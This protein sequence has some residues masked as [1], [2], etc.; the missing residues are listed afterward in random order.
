MVE[1]IHKRKRCPLGPIT[2]NLRH[3]FRFFTHI[4]SFSSKHT[5]PHAPTT[6]INYINYPWKKGM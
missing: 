4:R 5:H 6:M 2:S 3:H 1:D